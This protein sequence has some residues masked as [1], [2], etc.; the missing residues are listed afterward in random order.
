MSKTVDSK[1]VELAFNNKNFEKGV[2]QSIQTLENLNKSLDQAS[3][4][5]AFAKLTQSIDA[6]GQHFTISGQIAFAA[7]QRITHGAIDAGAALIKHLVMPPAMT[8]GF[9]EYELKMNSVQTI[10]AGTGEKLEI[11]NKY[12]NELN[13]YSDKTIY[14][15][16]DMT[17]NIGKFTNAGVKLPDA[18]GAI[19][20]I[21]NAAALAGANSN[22]ASRAMYNFAQAISTGSV[23]LIDWKS[24]ELANMGTVEFKEYLLDVAVAMGT[25]KKVAPGYYQS[26]TTDKQGNI[27]DTLNAV[28]MFSD[29][30][31][32]QWLTTEVLTKT[33]ND[34]A[35]S[36][37]EIG[38]RASEAAQRITT[39]SKLVDTVKEGIQSGW[40]Q[41]VETVLG[42]Y[43]EASDLWTTLGKIINT[44]TDDSA[45]ARIAML[46]F[47]KDQG[48]RDAI[49]SG[50]AN[51]LIALRKVMNSVKDGWAAI[52]PKNK[53]V[54]KL[55]AISK[56][57][58]S[59][60]S[61][62]I[63]SDEKAEQL[64]N[65]MAGLFQ[66]LKIG[67]TLF[68]GI[69]KILAKIVGQSLSKLIN[70]LSIIAK[71]LSGVL[72][73]IN[74]ALVEAFTAAVEALNV[75]FTISKEVFSVVGRYLG[76][77][78]SKIAEIPR[79]AKE[80]QALGGEFQITGN[81]IIDF[82]TKAY[83]NM[84]KLF[85]FIGQIT[86]NIREFIK[87][88][89]ESA[90]V[91]EFLNKIRD[92]FG[93]LGSHFADVVEKIRKHTN[94][95]VNSIN[96]IYKS[97]Q[98]RGVS[99]G[100]E[101]LGEKM[102]GFKTKLK[103]FISNLAK[104]GSTLASNLGPQIW[105]GVTRGVIA[106]HVGLLELEKTSPR[107]ANILK[108]M[109]TG[110]YR[111]FNKLY[112]II[113]D[114]GGTLTSFKKKII[115]V[116][117]AFSEGGVSK[118]FSNTIENLKKFEGTFGGVLT[119]IRNF[120]VGVI[121]DV[122]LIFY[123]IY[124]YFDDLSFK[125][126]KFSK[127]QSAG[128]QILLSIPQSMLVW[129]KFILRVVTELLGAVSR[130]IM[131]I[132]GIFEKVKK[133]VVNFKNNMATN[134]TK[135]IDSVSESAS[136][137]KKN[138]TSFWDNLFGGAKVNKEEIAKTGEALTTALSSTS[139]DE[140]DII[141]K[142]SGVLSKIGTA[143][144][145]MFSKI[146][147]P[148]AA[149]PAY[150]GELE[151]TSGTIN[152]EVKK[153][154]K[155]EEEAKS[156]F[157]KM[158]GSIGDFILNFISNING[159]K[160][161]MA[162]GIVIAFIIGRVLVLLTLGIARFIKGLGLLFAGVGNVL[163][164]ASKAF[165]RVGKEGLGEKIKAFAVLIGVLA[166]SLT[167]LT[168][169]DQ[170]KLLAA[171]IG[172]GVFVTLIT[173]ALYT[174]GKKVDKIGKAGDAI[175]SFGVFIALFTAALYGIS[176]IAGTN[177]KGFT[178]ALISIGSTLILLTGIILTIN[179][180][181]D[182]TKVKSIKSFS[183]VIAGL[184]VAAYLI[185]RAA[186][187]F[188]VIPEE[189]FWQ[190]IAGVT[191]A[192]LELTI[193]M[194]IMSRVAKG[195]SFTGFGTMFFGLAIALKLLLG[196]VKSFSQV[197]WPT[198]GK[199]L[200][201]VVGSLA[202][203]GVP[204]YILGAFNW[205][206]FE[207]I[208][209][210][211]KQLAVSLLILTAAIAL[212]G[213]FPN[214]GWAILGIGTF[215]LA[216]TK[217]LVVMAEAAKAGADINAIAKSLRNLFLGLSLLLGITYLFKNFETLKL[218]VILGGLSALVLAL[219]QCL[220][221]VAQANDKWDVRY[222]AGVI[223]K[224]AG[225]FALLM[226][227]LAPLAYFKWE[228]IT[229]AFTGL[230][231]AVTA[232]AIAISLLASINK[233]Y[234]IKGITEGLFIMALGFGAMLLAMTP[235]I[236]IPF[237]NIIA[238]VVAI[239]ALFGILA[240]GA[241][242]VA[243]IPQ[244]T[245]ILLAFAGAVLIMSA[246]MYVFG[247]G[248]NQYG[249]GLEK[250]SE[251]AT[252]AADGLRYFYD[253]L[254][255]SI[256]DIIVS[257]SAMDN[258]TEIIN[259]VANAFNNIAIALHNLSLT[260][261]TVLLTLVEAILKFAN[262]LDRN[263]EILAA[264]S[265]SAEE[266]ITIFKQ[267][268]KV[269][270]TIMKSEGQL[271]V[272]QKTLSSIMEFVRMLETMNANKIG[273]NFKVIARSIIDG[274]SEGLANI[275]QVVWPRVERGFSGLWARF[276]TWWE[277]N[278][279]S[280]K[281]ERLGNYIEEGLANGLSGKTKKLE[282]AIATNGGKAVGAFQ[283]ALSY[284]SYI[285][286]FAAT[287]A[288]AEEA[289]EQIPAAFA[290]GQLKALPAVTSASNA[291]V[292]AEIEPLERSVK[293][294]KDIGDLSGTEYAKNI[295]N[296]KVDVGDASEK[297]AKAAKSP[298][299]N[300]V[301]ASGG[302]GTL[303]GLNLAGNL[304]ATKPQ[305][306]KVGKN[307]RTVLLSALGMSLD[308]ES[309]ST[310]LVTGFVL[311][312]NNITI[313]ALVEHYKAIQYANLALA[314]SIES[315]KFLARAQEKYNNYLIKQDQ[316][317]KRALLRMGEEQI[318][319]NASQL[320]MNDLLSKQNKEI[321]QTGV[322]MSVLTEEQA[323]LI[324]QQKQSSG[325]PDVFNPAKN[326]M[327]QA[328]EEINKL[329]ETATKTN[330][331]TEK[332]T[333]KMLIEIA[334]WAEEKFGLI[335]PVDKIDVNSKKAIN[336][337][338]NIYE[339]VKNPDS[340][341]GLQGRNIY[342]KLLG[343]FGLDPLG[344][345]IVKDKKDEIT[346][347][348][349]ASAEGEEQGKKTGESFIEGLSEGVKD[350]TKEWL[351]SDAVAAI[352]D[353]VLIGRREMMLKQLERYNSILE[354]RKSIQEQIAE[355]EIEYE[356]NSMDMSFDE[357]IKARKEISKLKRLEAAYARRAISDVNAASVKARLEEQDKQQQYF[358]AYQESLEEAK[359]KGTAVN[360]MLDKKLND[361]L[362][363]TYLKDEE[364]AARV[365][366]Q[367]WA[368]EMKAKEEQAV[369]T[370]EKIAKTDEQVVED[371]EEP[372]VKKEAPKEKPE[373]V[374]E[375]PKPTTVTTPVDDVPAK[376][377]EKTTE[378]VEATKNFIKQ[379]GTVLESGS[380]TLSPIVAKAVSSS[381]SKT[382]ETITN[383][384][385]AKVGE[386]INATLG[387]AATEASKHVDEFKIIGKNIA[388]GLADGIKSGE[389]D[390]VTAA[391]TLAQAA[392]TATETELKVSSPSE[393]FMEIGRYCVEGLA[394]GFINSINLVENGVD[395]LTK[396]IISSIQN[397][398]GGFY[399]SGQNIVNTLAAGINSGAS[400]IEHYTN[401][402]GELIQKTM[403]FKNNINP[404]S[405]TIADQLASS[406]ALNLNTEPIIKPVI[407]LTNIQSASGMI[408]SIFANKQLKFDSINANSVAAANG[409]NRM[410]ANQLV[411]SQPQP[412]QP[413]I[414][415]PVPLNLTITNNV[416]DESDIRKITT[417]L[418]NVL[419]NYGYGR[420]YSL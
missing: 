374:V 128:I 162:I 288:Y 84:Q 210:I 5:E 79:R 99:G 391:K 340:T 119:S 66:V 313:N 325:V 175:K 113:S 176:K 258:M 411:A 212:I 133:T 297:L 78:F 376:I 393:K 299:I 41:S 354:K 190:G 392:K 154:E 177:P 184:G 324:N 280:K 85:T 140:K 243:A 117:A 108:V 338:K 253:I 237:E 24:I 398:G 105:L 290:N 363:A 110:F 322:E 222:I 167:V 112:D 312:L 217:G 157:Q 270:S 149:T 70:L 38:K 153:I 385:G 53:E 239:G 240:I 150:G 332:S 122:R 9:N 235:L 168:F 309:F 161:I 121:Q 257:S 251:Y 333:N 58:S 397:I 206:K 34:Y 360:G 200:L 221:L 14:S 45:K 207:G 71:S 67:K 232:I 382:A 187:A 293:D 259:T 118:V 336:L 12:L 275:D 174:L 279:P 367:K 82:L 400:T 21:A 265:V 255:N 366:Q 148:F 348:L 96:N 11:V 215:F 371:E 335:I 311:G 343:F 23:K 328:R 37:T 373:E 408:D 142:Q 273:N 42:D 341:T 29:G 86:L 395:I 356:A 139:I 224:M 40:A 28:Q 415:Q 2:G 178:A 126:K 242:A 36:E 225:G 417:N 412:Q 369:Q 361:Q 298:L 194:V 406:L 94:V 47:W 405:T 302:I 16:S 135:A 327:K 60:T 282:N 80:I 95:F 296:S 48:G 15:F 228:S 306:E 197:D 102:E 349:D 281:M 407:D 87:T 318:K 209:K 305:L 295:L 199:G 381:M 170:T 182:P 179:R 143:I 386:A 160:I 278:S 145:N 294:V 396:E 319:Q 76:E 267:L 269:L 57:F 316:E 97:F 132:D 218:G 214:F 30:L 364:A 289:S 331:E 129:V 304:D 227:S 61:L 8:D 124:Q 50:M 203:L 186:K 192:I 93:E 247:A 344:E 390:V 219:G 220:K 198:L 26:I 88:F 419:K 370:A 402:I 377:Q 89:K 301:Q 173:A 276:L 352:Y 17:S 25:V 164:S 326:K 13:E 307:L 166:A 69:A 202:A 351:T 55:A 64:T 188:A 127:T 238:G 20:G 245:I 18:V 101:A 244:V 49:I 54:S 353:K 260:P 346:E 98:E 91:Q 409:F 264:S 378:S 330:E 65:I 339:S 271:I 191:G 81:V 365:R 303:M 195:K 90:N 196:S 204:L 231:A 350:L 180:F 380:A 115:D 130:G 266:V 272:V 262:G 137:A 355:K 315:E 308:S 75:A 159:S 362:R 208:S 171:A 283:K 106:A 226:V 147:N 116:F 236:F 109:V 287:V 359:F 32:S 234:N 249:M 254:M 379:T 399:S 10:M 183:Y 205:T 292:K 357:R 83:I 420:G 131:N 389:I 268:F 300:A 72:D 241:T 337:V 92:K 413:E 7:L 418:N 404:V 51:V 189:N 284:L 286:P 185:A 46:Q 169:L 74:I 43:N 274:L 1:I 123:S 388:A 155:T 285:N 256:G 107:L 136:D 3:S 229:A 4:G 151:T 6:I 77:F 144:S 277:A 19:K 347:S 156:T 27:S 263:T 323:K 165:D 63:L 158:T 52:F 321:K 329:G 111:G 334:N 320:V 56:A 35:D 114:L 33:L 223:A 104:Y 68:G 163:D 358:R 314:D 181:S 230:V 73:L 172:L 103:I 100:M 44:V 342:N 141:K 345:Q 261:P 120:I 372:E 414:R 146:P 193:L 125:L 62:F 213:R 375:E 201:G 39:F 138:V 216:I 383:D 317:R 410:Q 246:A 368:D 416:R 22:E 387:S 401:Q 233:K 252:S 152:K 248:V 291:L 59:F 394:N 310:R 134:A 250:I 384:G 31:K 403:S 211:F